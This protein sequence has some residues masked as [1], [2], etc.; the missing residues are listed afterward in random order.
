MYGRPP[1]YFVWIQLLCLPMVNEQQF[2][3]FG[4]IETSQTEVNRA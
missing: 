2:F 4:Q 1:V 3:L